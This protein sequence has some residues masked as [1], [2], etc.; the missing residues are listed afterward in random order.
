MGSWQGPWE[1]PL[2]R[3]KAIRQH[4]VGKGER[5]EISLGNRPLKKHVQQCH[6]NIWSTGLDPSYN[7]VVVEF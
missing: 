6:N 1:W 7:D 4:T 2:E 5:D 3:T